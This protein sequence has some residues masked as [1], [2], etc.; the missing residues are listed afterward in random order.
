MIKVIHSEK[1]DAKV[2][3][4]VNMAQTDSQALD[5]ANKIAQVSRQFLNFNL[6][7]LGALP[8]DPHVPKAV[9][10]RRP[11]AELYPRSPATRAVKEVT[12]R[13]LNGEAQPAAQASGF[14]QRITAY[15]KASVD[16]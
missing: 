1:S 8:I 3:L 15:F 9:M 7:V 11:W 14:I 6:F 2:G 13:I 4:I 16:E 10:Q 5:V 12:A